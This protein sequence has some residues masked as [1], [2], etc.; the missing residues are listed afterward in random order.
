[1]DEVE[2]NSRQV[3]QIDVSIETAIDAEVAQIRRYPIEIRRVIAEHCDRHATLH[4]FRRQLCD[5]V[6]DVDYKF[7]IA[8]LV[9]SD[10]CCAY[11]DRRSLA[12]A[13]KMQE[14]AA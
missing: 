12:G 3:D 11:P 4:L 2:G 6:R 14:G 10:F 1:M 13:L 5:C 8:A 9:Y 7:V